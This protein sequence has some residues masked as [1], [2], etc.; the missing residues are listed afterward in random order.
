MS[1]IE[2]RAFAEDVAGQIPKYLPEEYADIEC[3]VLEGMKNNSVLKTGI[4]FRMPDSNAAPIVYMEPFY[5]EVQSGRPVES[6]LE[7]IAEC[8]AKSMP[9]RDLLDGLD[10]LSYDSV[11]ERLKVELI[12]TKANRAM[13]GSHPHMSMEDLSAIC[14]IE[15]GRTEHGMNATIKVSDEMLARWGIKREE[16]FQ[17]ALENTK[18][19]HPPI[20]LEMDQ[21]VRE[22]GGGSTV[23]RNFLKE[24]QAPD[25]E[26]SIYVLTNPSRTG[27][28][29]A[30]LHPETLE[31]MGRLF[32]EGYYLLP[33]SVHEFLIVPKSMGISP[34]ELGEMVRDVNRQAVSREE[35]LSD[36]VYEYDKEKGRILQV[37]ESIEKG[38]G[39]ER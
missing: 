1:I 36:R 22:M 25:F 27:G 2:V 23:Q 32:P 20:L 7:E 13:L 21:I 4:S 28:A 12:N 18:E 11:K 3:R 26:D 8:V 37:P 34:K 35:V 10:L 29:A 15:L 19:N 38:R 24:E 30:V 5:Q 16:L 17:K 33:S 9:S 39:M 6:V 14:R 31:Q